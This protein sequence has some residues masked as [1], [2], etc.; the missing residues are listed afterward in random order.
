[1]RL[2]ERMTLTDEEMADFVAHKKACG[3]L[4]EGAVLQEVS[5]SVP[6]GSSREQALE[7]LYKMETAPKREVSFGDFCQREDPAERG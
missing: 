6:I 2:T 5:L 7:E 1:M 3:T 4:P